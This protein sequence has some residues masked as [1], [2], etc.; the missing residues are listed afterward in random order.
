MIKSVIRSAFIT[1]IAVSLLG[2]VQG[3][4]AETNAPEAKATAKTHEHS[5]E[6]VSVDLKANTIT[7]KHEPKNLTFALTPSTKVTTNEGKKALTPADIKVGEHVKVHYTGEGS[8]MVATR[9]GYTISENN[10]VKDSTKAATATT[11]A[12]A[13]TSATTASETSKSVAS[14]ETAAASKLAPGTKININTASVE[15]LDKL[16][17]IGHVKA[18]AIVDYRTTNGPFKSPE[19]IENV[20]GIK[21]GTFSKIKDYIVVQ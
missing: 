3:V 19:D 20:K 9:I 8:S 15:E 6:V 13:S 7:I 16:P 5:G 10:E 1:A 18:Q 21:E 17:G 2:F 14:T 4:R 12:A 11:A